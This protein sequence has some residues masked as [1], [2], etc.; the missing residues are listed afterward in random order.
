MSY[1]QAGTSGPPLLLLHGWGAFKELWWSTM[2]ALAPDYRVFAIDVPGHGASPL[3]GIAT[4]ADLA[5][6]I[7][8]FCKLSG[9]PEVTLVGHSMGGNVALQLALLQPTLV[10]RLVLVDAAV[11]A[12]RLPAYVRPYASAAYGWTIIRLSMAFTRHFNALGLRVPHLHG[13]GWLRPWLRRTTYTSRHNPEAL[14][15]LLR[16]LFANPLSEQ[17]HQIRVPT[18]VVSGQF[19]GLV[20]LAHSRRLATLIPGAQFVVIPGAMHNPM[21]ERPKAFEQALRNFLKATDALV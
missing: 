12:Q 11:D 9:L 6:V 8:D 20:P 3:R 10:H 13:G 7:A 5:T 19:D 17:V 4:I 18:L 15:S 16:S 1:L 21:D 14:R 2:L